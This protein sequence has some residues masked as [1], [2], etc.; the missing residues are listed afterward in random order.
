M[1]RLN[2]KPRDELQLVRNGLIQHIFYCKITTHPE[3]QM[4][5]RAL[6]FDADYWEPG[7]GCCVARGAQLSGLSRIP[8]SLAKGFGR[9]FCFGIFFFFLNHFESLPELLKKPT[10][11]K[12][13]ISAV[14]NI[15]FPLEKWSAAVFQNTCCF[16]GREMPVF[17]LTFWWAPQ[18]V[19]AFLWDERFIWPSRKHRRLL[20]WQESFQPGLLQVEQ[21]LGLGWWP[22]W[23]SLTETSSLG[24]SWRNSLGD[25]RS[26]AYTALLACGSCGWLGCCWRVFLG[27]RLQANYLIW[28]NV[29]Q[30]WRWPVR[31]IGSSSLECRVWR[32]GDRCRN[33]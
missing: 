19:L 18:V 21:S 11:L 10:K 17:W 22:V 14:E 16:Q 26:T 12:Q 25:E 4:F 23:R 31:F 33:V 27:T 7:L 20:G 5:C 1:R 13:H 9:V 8:A 28:E 32:W 6:N 2:Q 15:A 3:L 30:P 24:E 29:L